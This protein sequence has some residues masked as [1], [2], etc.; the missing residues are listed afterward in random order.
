MLSVPSRSSPAR[1]RGSSAAPCATSCSDGLYSTST[2][3]A[4][5][6]SGRP[7]AYVADSDGAPF[8][9]PPRTAAGGSCCPGAGR[10]TS[11][12]SAARSRT[13]WRRATSRQRDRAAARRRRAVDPFAGRGDLDARIVRAV[14]RRRVRGRSD[15]AA[16]GG[17][18]R[19]GARLRD[20]AAYRALASDQAG[21][22]HEPAGERI[23]RGAAALARPG[24]RRLD[25]LGLLQPLGGSLDLADRAG[26]ARHTPRYRSRR[27]PPGSLRPAADL[28]RASG[29]ARS[30]CCGAR[31]RPTRRPRSL[32]R[33]RRGTEP[34]AFDALALHGRLDLADAARRVSRRRPAR[35]AAPWRRARVPPGAEIGVLLELIA[36]ERAAGM[37]STREEALEL[38][39]R[40]SR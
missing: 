38:V 25:G 29:A 4:P 12:R 5:I 10:S 33:F 17:P 2:S 14:W 16:A 30:R 1:R 18:L 20:R 23:L 27:L 34:W 8:H 32:H 31:L 11:R 22:R 19:G 35:A 7:R 39:R 24:W 13:T 21:S 26:A 9:S 6:R 28:A 40:Q 36:E 37:I 3:P 15:P